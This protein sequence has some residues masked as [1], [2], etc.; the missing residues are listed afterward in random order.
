MFSEERE[1]FVVF[2]IM[3]YINVYNSLLK[4]NK[5]ETGTTYF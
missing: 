4:F 2:V 1:L 3:D 5:P